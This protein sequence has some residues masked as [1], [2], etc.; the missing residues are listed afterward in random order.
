MRNV[1]F[2]GKINSLGDKGWW[3][4]GLVSESWR[5]NVDSSYIDAD[6]KANNSKVGGLI[7]KI[8]HGVNPMDVKQRGRLTKSVVKDTMTLKNHGQSG[9]V[10]H[11]NYNWGWVENNVSMMKVNNGEIM[12]GS[13]SVDSGDPDFGFHYFKNNVYVRDV[14]SGNVSYKRSK[15]IQG[16]D[17]AEAD[18]RIATFNITADKYEITDPLVNTLNNLTT[19]DNEYKTTQ[20]YKA[21]REQAYRNIE[22]L[23]PFYNK[24]WIVNQGNKLTDESNLVKKTVLSVTGMKAGQFVTDLSD[25][26]KIMVH[27]ADG[28]KE[29]LTVTAKTDSKVAQVKE[30]DVAGQNIVYTPN[31]VMKNRNQLASGIKE[32]LASVT[33]LSDEVRALM[34]KRE[35]PWQNTPEKKTEYIK[36]LYL[37]ESFAELKG[38]LEK[39]VSQILEN[40]DHQLNG[41][42]QSSVLYLRK[43]KIKKLKL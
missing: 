26:D 33:L 32:K 40:E 6:I 12:Y 34:D 30:Y 25:I 7:A 42:K 41:G 1:A 18:K 16:V 11:D 43:L 2:I 28:T 29:E 39:L 19:R 37:E 21:E 5:S 3:S 4:G 31:M 23:Q 22:K 9:G 36:G 27:Y 38:N 24:E 13:G 35:K 14:A 15:Q 20:D 8:D 10:I 17:Q